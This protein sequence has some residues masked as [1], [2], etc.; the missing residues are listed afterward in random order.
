[1]THYSK[2]DVVRDLD[3]LIDRALA[4]EAVVITR[5]GQPVVELRP[6][7]ESPA[8]SALDHAQMRALYRRLIARRQEHAPV[9]ITSVKLLDDMYD[10]GES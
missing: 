8:A 5:D 10:S 6:Q 9:G 1:M 7:Q 3:G 4:G 2:A